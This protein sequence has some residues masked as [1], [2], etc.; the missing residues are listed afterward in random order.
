LEPQNRDWADL[1]EG[2]K[3]F[4]TVSAQPPAAGTSLPE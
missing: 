2:V 4:P 1:T 3:G